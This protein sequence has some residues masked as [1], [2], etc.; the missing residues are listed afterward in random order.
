MGL[1]SLKGKLRRVLAKQMQV[2]YAIM[3]KTVAEFG[4]VLDLHAVQLVDTSVSGS[5]NNATMLGGEL[6]KSPHLTTSHQ[7]PV[8]HGITGQQSAPNPAMLPWPSKMAGCPPQEWYSRNPW[9]A[10]DMDMEE[11]NLYLFL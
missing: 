6:P 1:L 3:G 10:P 7:H 4:H 8:Q 9:A 5:S 2:E 11:M